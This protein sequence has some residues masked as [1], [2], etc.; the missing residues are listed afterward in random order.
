MGATVVAAAAAAVVVVLSNAICSV[1]LKYPDF[2]VVRREEIEA[3]DL[4]AWG[5]WYGFLADLE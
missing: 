3:V 5:T 1:T 4:N 2:S